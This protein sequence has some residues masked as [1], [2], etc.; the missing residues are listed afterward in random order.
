MINPCKQT[1][2]TAGYQYHERESFPYKSFCSYWDVFVEG[3]E[4]EREMRNKVEVNLFF[5]LGNAISFPPVVAKT[6]TCN[7]KMLR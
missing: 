5:L 1:S 2:Y 3:K 4:N 6:G 7:F